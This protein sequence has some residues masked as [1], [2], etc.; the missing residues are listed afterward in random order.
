MKENL[1]S[2]YNPRGIES[3]LYD[4]WEKKE[5]FKLP[6]GSFRKKESYV[7]VIPPPNITG[8][9]HMGHALNNTIQD[10]IIRQKRMEGCRA[11]WVPG[12]DHA[13]IATQNVV[14]KML[15]GKGI[16]RQE[17]GREKFVEEVWNWKEKYGSRIIFQ[18]KKLGA[19]CDWSRLRFTM[20]EALSRA[21]VEAFIRLFNKKLIYRGEK[22]IN[23]CPRC[24]TALSDEEV[25]YHDEEGMLY[26][27]RYPLASGGFITVA[28][29]RPETMLGDTAVAVNPCDG[30]YKKLI[31]VEVKLPFAGRL[32]KVISDEYVEPEFGTG[33]V[34]VT[35]SHDPND[36]EIGQ[37]H[38]LPFVT[39]INEDGIMNENAGVFEGLERFDCRKR[40]LNELEKEGLLEKREPYSNRTGHC[41]RCD[42]V[43][44]PYLSKQWFVNMKSLAEPAIEAA[45]TGKL[46]FYPER[47]KKV[48]LQWLYGIK[49][50]CISRQIW[51]GHR[52]PVWY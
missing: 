4:F 8:F 17:A 31:G 2:Q 49:D 24:T 44:E 42:T 33:A 32:V 36:F 16:S 51:W 14:E 11:L 27:I 30:R 5:Y 47:W 35:P 28:T 20:D 29:T 40:L 39:V 38:N 34:K 48:Y 21:V 1:D 22:I 19:S 18:L 25:D 45:E 6:S 41:Y 26:Y 12:T 7:I 50:W 23:W 37:R 15:A 13:G 46:K 3:E 9:L 10:I 43:I 52:I